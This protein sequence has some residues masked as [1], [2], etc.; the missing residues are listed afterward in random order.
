MSQIP[1]IFIEFNTHVMQ[2]LLILESFFSFY[3]PN[4]VND[5]IFHHEAR[6]FIKN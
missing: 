4:T 5:S 6:T 1:I 2:N 3:L